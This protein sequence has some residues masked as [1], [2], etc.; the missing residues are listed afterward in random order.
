MRTKFDEDGEEAILAVPKMGSPAVKGNGILHTPVSPR[1]AHSS[2]FL[3]FGTSDPPPS[4]TSTHFDDSSHSSLLHPSSFPFSPQALGLFS[5]ALG[6]VSTGFF[7]ARC[8][9]VTLDPWEIMS[10]LL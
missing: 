9:F 6:S 5:H 10:Q 7:Y 1:L 3:P 2:S 4:F 8:S